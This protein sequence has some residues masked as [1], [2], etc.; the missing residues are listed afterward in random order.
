MFAL[1]P[2]I[3]EFGDANVE[4]DGEGEC[5]SE[6]GGD[7]DAVTLHDG[8]VE[9]VGEGHGSNSSSGGWKMVSWRQP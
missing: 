3:P 7:V 2:M 8:V 9:G 5:S 1:V 6:D 4:A